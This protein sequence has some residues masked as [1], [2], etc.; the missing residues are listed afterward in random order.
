MWPNATGQLC[1]P[2]RAADNRANHGR[3][4]AVHFVFIEGHGATCMKFDLEQ[5]QGRGQRWQAFG[6]W[7]LASR[8]EQPI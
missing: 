6:T 8:E 3:I 1:T 5:I 7:R 4:L 2:L